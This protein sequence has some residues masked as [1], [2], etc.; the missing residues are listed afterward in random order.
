MST[1]VHPPQISLA[2]A[3]FAFQ[4]LLDIV[5]DAYIQ[6]QLA[7]MQIGS[8]NLITCWRI[9]WATLM[10]ARVTSKCCERSMDMVNLAAVYIPSYPSDKCTPN[11]VFPFAGPELKTYGSKQLQSHRRLDCFAAI[12]KLQLGLKYKRLNDKST[13]IDSIFPSDK[14]TIAARAFVG[15]T[16]IQPVYHIPPLPYIRPSPVLLAACCWFLF[17][18]KITNVRPRVVGRRK[19]LYATS[20]MLNCLTII[21]LFAV[22]F[23]IAFH[24]AFAFVT[25]PVAV[26]TH[27]HTYTKSIQNFPCN[28]HWAVARGFAYFSSLFFLLLILFVPFF[29]RISFHGKFAW[30]IFF[31]WIRSLSIDCTLNEFG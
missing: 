2:L 25:A 10:T 4:I 31:H 9:S 13:N 12:I 19:V 6:F 28:R 18:W 14:L 24:L 5:S 21:L 26:R 20:S 22:A 27:T 15:P 8:R 7:R 23:G 17:T 16:A 3:E 30:I 1:M 11:I 29:Q